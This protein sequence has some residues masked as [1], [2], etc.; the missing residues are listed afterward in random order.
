VAERP[1]RLAVVG[2]GFAG[3]RLLLPALARL[4]GATVVAAADPDPATHAAARRAGARVSGRW[5]DAVAADVDAVV[6]ATPAPQHAAVA[7]AALGAGRHVYVE[8]PMCTSVPDAQALVAAATAAGRVVQVGHAYRFHPLWRRARRLVAAARLVPPLRAEARFDAVR[9]A[10]PGWGHPVV[11]LG[12]HHL[13]LMAWLLGRWPVQ[14]RAGGATLLAEWPDGSRLSGTY[15]PGP[16]ADRVVLTDAAG[17]T[18]TVDRLR[19]LRLSGRARLG[20]GRFPSVALV[21]AR[22]A[23]AGW[24]RSFE[25]A[26]RA[27]VGAVRAGRPHPGAAGPRD[28]LAGVATCAA[29]VAALESGRA[30]PVRIPAAGG[31]VR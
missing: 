6:V 26:L 22:L 1:V 24:E 28:G 17:R 10:G 9:P 3:S 29:V 8:K 12:V 4:P 14:V 16:G 30:E 31:A 2:L 27:F 25:W 13:D 11:D 7:E 15:A 23:G 20:A 19:G 18:V 21:G 5:E